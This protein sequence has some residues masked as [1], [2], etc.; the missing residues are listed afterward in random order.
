VIDISDDEVADSRPNSDDYMAAQLAQRPVCF[1]SFVL[2]YFFYDGST[3]GN[4]TDSNPNDGPSLLASIVIHPLVTS[5]VRSLCALL[6]LN[7]FGYPWV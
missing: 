5:G 1:R 3:G 7:S 4:V 6:L 2:F